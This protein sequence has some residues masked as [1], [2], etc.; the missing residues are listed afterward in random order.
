MSE[1]MVELKQQMSEL[2]KSPETT[3]Q[4]QSIIQPQDKYGNAVQTPTGSID[5]GQLRDK[6]NEITA[7]HNDWID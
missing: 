1:Q 4:A 7:K 3:T 6:L 5:Q 2:R